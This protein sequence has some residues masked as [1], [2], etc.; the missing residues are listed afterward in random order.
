ME[1]EVKPIDLMLGKIQINIIT[2]TGKVIAFTEG[3]EVIDT[4]EITND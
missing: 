2:E 4:L 3:W 1:I